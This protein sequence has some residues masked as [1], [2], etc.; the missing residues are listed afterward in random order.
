MQDSALGLACFMG[1]AV[2]MLEPPVLLP[3]ACPP[4]LLSTTQQFFGPSYKT[5]EVMRGSVWDQT[6]SGSVY[7]P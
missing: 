2:A 3:E 1:W 6:G 5:W 4:P 7:C